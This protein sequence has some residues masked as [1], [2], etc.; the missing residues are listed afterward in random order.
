MSIKSAIYQGAGTDMEKAPNF[1]SQIIGLRRLNNSVNGNPRF[2]ITFANGVN[3]NSQSDAAFC[4]GI[5]NPNMRGD[6]DVWLSARG[7]VAY[8]RPAERKGA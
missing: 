8:V 7:T 3:A 2:N 5:E 6:V 1:T 4:Y